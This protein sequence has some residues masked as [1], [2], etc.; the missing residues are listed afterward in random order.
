MSQESF[1]GSRGEI[2][3]ARDLALAAV[4]DVGDL[5]LTVTRNRAKARP[6]YATI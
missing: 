4:D 2:A 1:S 5:E 6:S 3:W